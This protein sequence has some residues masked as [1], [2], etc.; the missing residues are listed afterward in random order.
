MKQ[1]NTNQNTMNGTGLI[2]NCKL[3]FVGFKI[4]F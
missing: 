1:E 2:G 3:F 4:N